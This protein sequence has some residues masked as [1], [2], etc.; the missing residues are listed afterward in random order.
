MTCFACGSLDNAVYLRVERGRL[1]DLS[2]AIAVR[3]RR[4]YG[5]NNYT[6]H[7]GNQKYLQRRRTVQSCFFSPSSTDDWLAERSNSTLL[8]WSTEIFLDSRITHESLLLLKSAP[9]TKWS[10]RSWYHLIWWFFWGGG[11]GLITLEQ[12]KP[13]SFFSPSN[14]SVSF[15]WQDVER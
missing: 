8:S 10:R 6:C 15:L 12:L 3:T 13:A 9:E 4:Q 11:G 5:H 2:T 14:V 7:I 1:N